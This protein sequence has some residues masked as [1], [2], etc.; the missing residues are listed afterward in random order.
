MDCKR[1]EELLI[2]FIENQLV[3]S[4][5][6]AVK[7]HL[8]ECSNCSR[9]VEEYKEFRR[10]LNE[11]IALEPSSET[12]ARLSKAARDA[13][14]RDRI[15]FWKKWLYSPI[16]VPALGSALALFLWISYGKDS[17]DLFFNV[18]SRYSTDVMAKKVPSDQERNMPI[19]VE[20]ALEDPKTVQP[21]V[22]SKKRP[23]VIPK[24]SE[25]DSGIED[26]APGVPPSAELRAGELKETDKI[27]DYKAETFTGSVDS[28]ALDKAASESTTQEE[29]AK[30]HELAGALSEEQVGRNL[31]HE[32]R[33]KEAQLYSSARDPY[34]E[35]LDLALKQQR[36]GDCETSIKTSEELLK[37]SPPPPA[38]LIE[39]TYL[40]LAECYERGGD[41]D[42]AILNYQNLQKAASEQ[43]RFAEDKIEDIRQKAS[44]FRAKELEL[45]NIKKESQTQ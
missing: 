38:A 40:S 43:A 31:E 42:R 41:W 9:E 11:E 4:D 6:V 16:L 25:F 37:A 12:L 14:K 26:E 24:G 32:E 28:G 8:S 39:E 21:L 17:P 35:K 34:Q 13:V 33:K 19:A 18:K 45:G 5:M 10:M 15:P 23:S 44:L 2:E 7:K 36:E 30:K 20:P 27:S 22:S 29:L 1:F 3:S